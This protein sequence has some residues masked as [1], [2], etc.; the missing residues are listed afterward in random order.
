MRGGGCLFIFYIDMTVA[1]V[2]SQEQQ[3]I[4]DQLPANVGRSSVV[5]SLVRSLGLLEE[6][7]GA[8][9][10]APDPTLGT[11][12]RLLRYHTPAYVGSSMRPAHHYSG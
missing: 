5:H 8:R 3:S 4:A 2:W 11:R 6:C 12:E 7:N 9:V 1:Y 10:I